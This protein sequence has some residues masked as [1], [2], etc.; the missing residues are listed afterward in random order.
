MTI[1]SRSRSIL[2][3]TLSLLLSK[4]RQAVNDS[5]RAAERKETSGYMTAWTLMKALTGQRELSTVL[6]LIE[7]QIHVA[8][9]MNLSPVANE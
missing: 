3:S 8:C 2:I 9:S 5:D 7:R 1:S 6:H 4:A